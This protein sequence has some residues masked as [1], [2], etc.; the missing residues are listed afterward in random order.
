MNLALRSTLITVA[1]VTA[2]SRAF[3]QDA[4]EPP[5]W[6]R[7]P[8]HALPPPVEPGVAT[9]NDDG[10]DRVMLV[11][12]STGTPLQVV[13]EQ[14]RTPT[15]QDPRSVSGSGTCSTPCALHIPRASLFLRAEAVGL[16][17]TDM[18]LTAP[19]VD[20]RIVLR[21]ASRAQWN[22]GIGLTAVGTTLFVALAALGIISQTSGGLD[23]PPASAIGVSVGAGA[24]LAVG[25][26]L[27]W[28]NRTGIARST[29][30]ATSP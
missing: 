11:I 8:R 3:A 1:L 20:S 25:I 16:R 17:D 30:L 14:R 2:S 6:Q 22:A 27:L 10:P 9:F 21:S 26:P 5:P 15:R 12:E 29:A 4:A 19:S 7:A 18:E 23:I 28:F 13:L 24:L